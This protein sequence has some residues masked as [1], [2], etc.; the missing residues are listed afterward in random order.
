MHKYNKVD[1][2]CS[3]KA[4]WLLEGRDRDAE[5]KKKVIEGIKSCLCL[6]LQWGV[7]VAV[8]DTAAAL[9]SPLLFV[10][11]PVPACALCLNA[12]FLAK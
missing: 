1:L 2:S 7:E 11:F 5:M 3:E 8:W 10:L 9:T 6:L 12:A 4:V